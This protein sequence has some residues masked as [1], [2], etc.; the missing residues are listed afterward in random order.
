MHKKNKMKTKEVK[1][2]YEAW[3]N[4]ETMHNSS[5]KWLSELKFAKDEQLFFDLVKF[6]SYPKSYKK[7]K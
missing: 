4:T 5:V 3:L 7:E 1:V 2:K 6:L